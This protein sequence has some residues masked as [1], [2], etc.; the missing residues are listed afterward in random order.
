MS[1]SGKIIE[2]GKTSTVEQF[3]KAGTTD[4]M[5][6]SNYSIK[7]R[8][9]QQSNIILTANNIIHDYMDEIKPYIQTVYFS[10]N[11][12][13]KYKYKP[14]LFAYDVYGSTELFFVIMAL[15]GICDIKDFNKRTVKA[16]YKVHMYE[17]LNEIYN[18]ESNYL[19]KN[20]SDL[21]Y[22]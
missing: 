9:S 1:Y 17:L 20:K 4:E 15:N 3:I 22:E 18:A 21:N 2:T 16:L 14:K 11:E 13:I 19:E 12:Y 6:Y 8:S 10:E 5:T 7:F